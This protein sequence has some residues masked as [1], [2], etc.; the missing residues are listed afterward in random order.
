MAC[1]NIDWSTFTFIAAPGTAQT[2]VSATELTGLNGTATFDGASRTINY[3]LGTINCLVDLIQFQVEDQD[4]NISNVGTWYLDTDDIIAPTL[5]ADSITVAAGSTTVL[6]INANDTG[7]INKSSYE[8]TVFPSTLKLINNFD[9]TVTIIAPDTSEGVETFDYVASTP[10]GIQGARAT[11]TVTIENAGVGTSATICGVAGVDLTSFLE[12]DVTA[13]GSWAAD[14]GNPSSPSIATP[15]SVDF[16]AANAGV[17]NF[18]Y[19][20][21]SST[22]TITLTLP[23]YGVTINTVSTP[24]DNPVAASIQ[25]LVQFTTVGVSNVNNIEIEVDFNSGTSFDYYSPDRWDAETGFGSVT[26]TYGSGAG[27]YD[28][29]VNAVDD[30][31]DTQTASAATKTI[32]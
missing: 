7:N 17:Y 32:T 28:I 23:D 18:T 8:I 9:G 3:E 26:I 11:V 25:S 13:G 16:S 19:T 20:V 4:G 14:A 27:T 2:L 30:C 10:E 24:T 22:A 31:G 1:T 29:D 15:T 5:T 21:G 6:D 12:G